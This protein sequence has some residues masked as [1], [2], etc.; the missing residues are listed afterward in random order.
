M[1]E[2]DLN[3]PTTAPTT[4]PKIA[5]GFALR[6]LMG[7]GAAVLLLGLLFAVVRM[8]T[9]SQELK[10]LESLAKK[11]NQ[12]LE[13]FNQILGRALDVQTEQVASSPMQI[14]ATVE[15]FERLN[16][17]IA[18]VPLLQ[19]APSAQVQAPRLPVVA[20]A[21]VNDKPLNA[22]LRWWG[23][24]GQYVLQPI[25]QYLTQLIQVRVMDSGLEQLAMTQH[26]QEA[27]RNEIVLRILTA[28]SLLLLGQTLTM[29]QEIV[30]VK[31]LIEANFIPQDTHTVYVLQELATIQ[32]NMQDMNIKNVMTSSEIGDKK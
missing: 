13:N 5:T 27:L 4:A 6:W 16:D 8:N 19:A 32:K 28:R 24:V 20:P 12:Q 7:V 21:P 30:K 1:T 14:K 26:S 2:A 10:K 29:H 31:K 17:V 3:A 15:I 18:R 23:Q 9:L 25:Q 22:E 11:N